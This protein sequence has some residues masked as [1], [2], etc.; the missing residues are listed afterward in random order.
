MNAN[1][2]INDPQLKMVIDQDTELRLVAEGFEFVEGP[3]WHLDEN[4]LTFNDIPASRTYRW[5]P[6]QGVR[7]LRDRTNKANGNTY[8]NFGHMVVCEHATS[9]LVQ[10]D[11]NGQVIKTM[12]SNYQGKELNSPN[13]VVVSRSGLI[14]FTDPN[15]GRKPGRVGIERPQQLPFQGVY[16]FNPETES[17]SLLID[18]LSNPNGLCFSPDESKLYVN[19]SPNRSIWVYDIDPSGEVQNGSIFAKTEGDG[20]GLPD[21]M[22]VDREGRVYCAAQGGIHI[23]SSE[24]VFLGRLRCPN[25]VANFCFGDPDLR[26]LYLTASD[27]IY[28]IRIRAQGTFAGIGRHNGGN[29]FD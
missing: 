14:Y 1:W 25:Q 15:F 3:V 17:L 12:A 27:K 28:Q 18:D 4:H 19:D 16:R 23:W 2:E 8:D 9:R 5:F 29:T 7:I 6:N 13:D 11:V 20:P 26:T 10:T 21:G 22:K 24:G